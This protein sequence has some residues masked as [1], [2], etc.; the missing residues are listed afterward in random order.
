MKSL[1]HFLSALLLGA[2]LAL[3]FPSIARADSNVPAAPSPAPSAS[4][5]STP[6]TH[7]RHPWL[8]ALYVIG[9]AAALTLLIV[10]AHNQ[11]ERDSALCGCN[12][13]NDDLTS[14]TTRRPPIGLALRIP[15]H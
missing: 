8:T 7:A 3:Q 5:I 6:A 10:S 12:D 9:G 1:Q 2:V 15:I 13:N 14:D 4:P 11:C